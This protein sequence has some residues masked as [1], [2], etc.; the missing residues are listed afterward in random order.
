MEIIRNAKFTSTNLPE[1]I[2]IATADVPLHWNG[3][4]RKEEENQSWDR[5]FKLE[6]MVSTHP[7]G[8]GPR[9]IVDTGEAF[10]WFDVA[11][12]AETLGGG[13]AM[14]GMLGGLGM[15]GGLGMGMGMFGADPLLA[16][17]SQMSVS[18]PETGRPSR[19]FVSPSAYLDDLMREWDDGFL[20]RR[21]IWL[22]G[23]YIIGESNQDACA[24]EMRLAREEEA[25]WADIGV[26]GIEIR[27]NAA[28]DRTV[29]RHWK[30]VDEMNQLVHFFVG[31]K[32]HGYDKLC[33]RHAK[34]PKSMLGAYPFGH[35]QRGNASHYDVEWMAEKRFYG[36]L[37]EGDWD[38]MEFGNLVTQVG[39]SATFSKSLMSEMNKTYTKR[40]DAAIAKRKRENEEFHQYNQEL[41]E[42]LRQRDVERQAR[43]RQHEEQLRA[44]R[45]RRLAWDRKMESDRRVRDAWSE[46]IRGTERYRDPYGHMVEMQVTG[47]N[48][49]AFYDRSTGRTVMSD[50]TD[51]D[52]PVDWEELPRW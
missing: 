6:I 9:I 22:M 1:E 49:R 12:M 30:L 39:T 50:V 34:A 32:L 13:S 48:Q 26:D 20:A 7:N 4:A 35:A 47:P 29:M 2:L 25:R 3:S 38:V 21:Q 28:L 52:K 23:D 41:G 24:R 31:A 33:Y 51:L 36:V 19:Q 8:I 37:V 45:E 46:A 10:S 40:A 16:T 5:P 15:F 43:M 44:D 42:K 17:M 18:V 27:V 14:G 11:S